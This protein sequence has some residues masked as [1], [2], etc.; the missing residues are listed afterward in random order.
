MR[1][2]GL[3]ENEGDAE[4]FAAYLVTEGVAAH[5][6]V[7]GDGWAIWVR[8]ENQVD[9]AK[10]AFE[11]FCLDPN[12]QQYTQVRQEAERI[13]RKERKQ[14]EQT[15]KNM[16]DIRGKWG[17]P[18]A[19]RRP[20]VVTLIALSAGVALASK[21]GAAQEGIFMR[22]LLFCDT[23]QLQGWDPYQ[24][25]DRL[26]DIRQGELWRVI[27][28]IF[29]HYGPWHLAFNMIMFY[30]LGGLVEDRRGTWRTGL[31]VLA[32]AATSNT[33]QALVPPSL[34]GSPL[35]AGMSGVVYGMFGYI[36]IK[37]IYA[38]EMGFYIGRSTVFILMLWLLLG[39]S[40]VLGQMGMHI[41][42]WTHAIGFLVGVAIAYAPI[43]LQTPRRT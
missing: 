27:T 16:V 20:L 9:K 19:S 1:Q 38:P 26:I 25:M 35:A 34:G 23:M 43:A 32:I 3:L 4:R 6:E 8:D 30:Q 41:A 24:L 14:R 2:V 11:D 31:M 12:G 21:M 28:P 17:R 29:V 40:G 10:E 7:D 37:S 5:A 39:I 13:L 42:N 15:R 18:S 33:V 22:S 36:W